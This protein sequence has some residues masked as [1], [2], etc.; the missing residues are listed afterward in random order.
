[1]GRYL[2][3]VDR[4]WLRAW[5]SWWWS[6][7]RELQVTSTV[8]RGQAHPSTGPCPH[9]RA[10]PPVLFA[11]VARTSPVRSRLLRWPRH[12]WP[13]S[14]RSPAPAA[15]AAET[16]EA[17][18]TRAPEPPAWRPQACC[19]EEP[20]GAINPTSGW[21][22]TR[23]RGSQKDQELDLIHKQFPKSVG[24]QKLPPKPLAALPMTLHHHGTFPGALP[25]TTASPRPVTLQPGA[26][27]EHQSDLSTPLLK[28]LR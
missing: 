3:G 5:E 24:L 17:A 2:V 14:D 25:W 1:M 23:P 9:G 15:R 12:W 6:G 11:W 4:L 7:G 28:T 16:A 19:R 20:R 27:P 18:K 21:F 8:G 22:G 10:A 13:P 26:L